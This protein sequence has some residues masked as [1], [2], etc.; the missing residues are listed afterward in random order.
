MT[1]AELKD[2][3][4]ISEANIRKHFGES[5]IVDGILSPELYFSSKKKIMWILKEPYDDF[6]ENGIPC[7]G[8]WH[9]NE[10]ILEK[11]NISDFHKDSRK[12]FEPMIYATYSILN[13][14]PPSS[15]MPCIA[16]KPDMIDALKG[17]AYVNVKKT[18]GYKKSAETIITDSY[19]RNRQILLEQIRLFE[20]EIVIFGYT[21]HHFVR[22]L[23]LKM[24]DRKEIGKFYYYK[25][26]N[27]LF[28]GAYH[29]S[30]WVIGKWNYIDT[31]IEI[32]KKETE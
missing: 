23:N 14:Y 22:D 29:P 5:V 16:D 2:R 11:K 9:F 20:P 30:C 10:A 24:D 17:I 31:I 18:P 4:K 6:D 12:T 19:I 21:L 15:E 13:G 1:L 3:I 28:L 8:G 26:P 25:S 7:G 27:K 32:C